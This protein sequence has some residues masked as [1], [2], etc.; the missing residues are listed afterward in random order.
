MRAIS[1]VLD[2]NKSKLAYTLYFIGSL[3][4]HQA[5]SM[6]GNEVDRNILYYRYFITSRNTIFRHFLVMCISLPH[7]IVGKGNN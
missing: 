6:K 3:H 5:D 1:P 7:V 4:N 2:W